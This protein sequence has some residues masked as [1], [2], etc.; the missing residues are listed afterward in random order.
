MKSRFTFLSALTWIMQVGISVALPLTLSVLLA[1]FLRNRYG[2]GKW[3]V[4][5]GVAVG[6]LGAAGGLVSSLR[7]LHRLGDQEEKPPGGFNGY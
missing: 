7:S 6:I 4:A 5:V 3:I 1:V 2:I